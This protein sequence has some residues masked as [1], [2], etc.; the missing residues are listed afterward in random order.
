MCCLMESLDIEFL[1][2]KMLRHLFSFITSLYLS[3][4][5]NFITM[6]TAA[7]IFWFVVFAVLIAIQIRIEL[8]DKEA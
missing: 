2:R 6:T 7:G 5:L 4:L 1:E 8:K 3:K